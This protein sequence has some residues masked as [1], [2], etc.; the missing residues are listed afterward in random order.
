MPPSMPPAA[1]PTAA[2]PPATR[3][4]N[5]EAAPESLPSAVPSTFTGGF[6][7]ASAR[8]GIEDRPALSDGI[9]TLT[10]GEVRRTALT[11]AARL[12][13]AGVTKGERVALMQDRGLD[14]VLHLV[15]L[16]ILGA[17]VAVLNCRETPAELAAKI[18]TAEITQILFNHANAALARNVAADTGVQ[19]RAAL[20]PSAE[21][22][23]S[24]IPGTIPGD[25]S[26]DDEALIL[27]TSGSSGEAKAVRVSQ[28]NIVCNAK[29][30]AEA[31]TMDET[32]H[33]LHG[34]P[35][36]HTNGV[37]N[38]I[39]L[40]LLIG[41][42]VTLLERFKADTF[43]AEMCRHQ[44]TIITGVPTM[45]ARLLDQPVPPG[46][47]GSL[48]LARCGSAPITEDLHRRIEAHLGVHL[49]VS[50]GQ[51]E[52]TC[53]STLNPPG[54]R[55]IGSVGRALAGQ[56]VGILALKSD[57]VLATGETGEVAIRGGNVALGY[58]KSGYVKSGYV[59]GGYVDSETFAPGGWLRTGDCGYLDP[60]GYLF[61]TGRLKEIIIRGGENLSPTQIEQ[62]LSSFPGLS[63]CC[64]CGVPDQDLGEV[65]AA[66]VVMTKE[67]AAKSTGEE[68]DP[69]PLNAHLGQHLSKA[70]ALRHVF[71]RHSLPTN[72]IGKI[73]RKALQRQAAALVT[74]KT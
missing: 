68:T 55:K 33:L 42:R 20:S 24:T 3:T 37:L 58:V 12:A 22:T 52:A 14:T 26:G 17:P 5:P 73:D 19:A 4:P 6:L 50:Y 34:M 9:R 47:L 16:V 18:R 43:F 21:D 10:H 41:A 2:I 60:D 28:G 69:A 59:K 35:L 51:S 7:A 27:F 15:A 54:A 29:G 38:Q 70:H 66:F 31:A 1:T 8:A 63:E 67:G 46:A 23:V 61:L 71:P 64:V 56:E 62:A 65:P 39:L 40:P 36:Y 25:S 74:E 72:A 30:L 48:R 53:T 13:D 57:D 32:D 44:P 11:L 49:I 45:Y